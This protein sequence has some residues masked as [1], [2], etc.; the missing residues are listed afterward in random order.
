MSPTHPHPT[1]PDLHGGRPLPPHLAQLKPQPTREK[2]LPETHQHQLPPLPAGGT[3]TPS[4]VHPSE[5]HRAPP[6]GEAAQLSLTPQ[7]TLCTQHLLTA[8]IAS[9]IG[10]VYACTRMYVRIVRCIGVLIS[11]CLISLSCRLSVYITCIITLFLINLSNV[12]SDVNFCTLRESFKHLCKKPQCTLVSYS[13]KQT[14]VI[15][16]KGPIFL[17]QNI[18]HTHKGTALIHRQYYRTIIVSGLEWFHYS[19]LYTVCVLCE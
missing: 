4:R 10:R 16:F 2:V 13:V 18:K 9:H 19:R 7:V 3:V 8:P 1:L 11:I 17:M 12:F 5:R 15:V 14:S 6:T